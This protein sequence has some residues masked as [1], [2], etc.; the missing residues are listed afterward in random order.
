VIALVL[1]VSIGISLKVDRMEHEDE[2]VSDA[3]KDS[4]PGASVPPEEHSSSD[5]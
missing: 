2:L 1:V 3:F 5:V 4:D